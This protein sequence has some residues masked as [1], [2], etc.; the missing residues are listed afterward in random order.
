ME[1]RRV[2]EE[3]LKQRYVP[4][5]ESRGRVSRGVDQ[6]Q[7]PEVHRQQPE[8][9]H[10]EGG[11]PSAEDRV[12]DDE[13]CPCRLVVCVAHSGTSHRFWFTGTG[14]SIVRSGMGQRTV[15]VT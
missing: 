10:T 9:R 11:H 14:V 3:A 12:V 2:R 1:N 4:H 13:A 5:V 8:E 15:T 6:H 7:E